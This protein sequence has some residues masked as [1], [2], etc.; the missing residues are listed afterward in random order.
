[1]FIKG[2]YYGDY[3]DDQ[4]SYKSGRNSW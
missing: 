4:W 2:L 1:L 3:I